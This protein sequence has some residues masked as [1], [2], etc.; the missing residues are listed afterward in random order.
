MTG[1]GKSASQTAA[2]K[3]AGVSHDFGGAPV[4]DDVSFSVP[5]ASFCALL[6]PNGAGKTTFL[7]VITRLYA[8]QTGTIE[9]FGN[10]LCREPGS[11]LAQLG[12]V[13]PATH[14]RP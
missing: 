12:I 2:L 14:A 1:S 3:I 11:A 8:C 6:G 5:A 13:F 7:S 4:V 10:D 9:V